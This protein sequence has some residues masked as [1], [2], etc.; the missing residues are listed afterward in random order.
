MKA[1]LNTNYIRCAIGIFLAVIIGLTLF[2][3]ANNNTKSYADDTK[4]QVR[5]DNFEMLCNQS[6]GSHAE[7]WSVG[8]PDEEC[9][10]A[11]N[12]KDISPVPTSID[13]VSKSGDP[14]DD[15]PAFSVRYQ[16]LVNDYYTEPGY[17]SNDYSS[18]NP[19]KIGTPLSETLAGVVAPYLVIISVGGDDIYAPISD[20]PIGIYH[21]VPRPVEIGCQPADPGSCTGI[22]EFWDKV[23]N[24]NDKIVIKT[25]R[26]VG[27]KSEDGVSLDQ[28]SCNTRAVTSSGSP[29]IN[30][31]MYNVMLDSCNFVGT[32]KDNYRFFP[33]IDEQGNLVSYADAVEIL[34]RQIPIQACNYARNQ[35]NTVSREDL[36]YRDE[37]DG[38]CKGYLINRGYKTENAE[39]NPE[40]FANQTDEDNYLPLLKPPTTTGRMIVN[41]TCGLTTPGTYTNCIIE[42]PDHK[43]PEYLGP[44]NPDRPGEIIKNYYTRVYS[45]YVRIDAVDCGIGFHF[46]P[47]NNCVD[48][49][50][51]PPPD[52]CEVGFHYDEKHKCVSDNDYCPPGLVGT[53]PNDCHEPGY[54]IKIEQIWVGTGYISTNPGKTITIGA[55][56]KPNDATN[57]VLNWTSSDIKT[58]TVDKNGKVKALR[59][60]RVVIT[61]SA[62]DGSKTSMGKEVVIS[63]ANLASSKTAKFTD[64]K[65]PKAVPAHRITAINWMAKKGVTQCLNAKTLKI[66]YKCKFN[67]WTAVNRSAMTQFVWK[68]I[69]RPT[70]AGQ[71]V[72]YFKNEKDVQ[73]FKKSNPER[74]QT[75][76]WVANDGI[77]SKTAKFNG[78]KAISR[79]DMA[80]WMYRLAGKPSLDELPQE[81]IKV[82]KKMF[83]DVKSNSTSEQAT[84]IWWIAYHEITV[85]VDKNGKVINKCAYNLK[86]PVNRGSMSEFLM[87][88]HNALIKEV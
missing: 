4:W 26:V 18:L 54:Q 2:C 52:G 16:R 83:T 82:I 34:P 88:L 57:K 11:Y 8:F 23:Y 13:Y 9:I 28:N 64:L 59:V 7:M 61:A 3:F 51:P 72:T 47:P 86:N 87:K 53:P 65:K 27:I 77:V 46:E 39:N 37:P 63:L 84:A 12:G 78:S 35:G 22:M 10:D 42:D 5:S 81:R 19:Y 40:G 1:Q 43:F 6:S 17:N 85:C 48:D 56:I 44:A 41:P 45:G 67:P 14:Q 25:M 36:D 74:F 49:T 70:Y 71:K 20:L 30:V 55:Q 32:L 21:V 38:S 80:I 76:M 15:G 29:G 66:I 69:G 58:A 33:Q 73:A 79:A 75:V 31:G 62:T 60:G 24:G 68:L 50:P